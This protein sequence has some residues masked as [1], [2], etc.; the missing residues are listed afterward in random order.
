MMLLHQPVTCQDLP[1]ADQFEEIGSNKWRLSASVGYGWRVANYDGAKD[2]LMAYGF[3]SSA[4][5][6]YIKDIKSGYKIAGQV[7]YMIW[8]N[9]GL[10]ID[11]SFFHASAGIAGYVQDLQFYNSHYVYLKV[12]DNVFTNYVGASVMSESRFGNDKFRL[13]SQ[14]SLGYTMYREELLFNQQQT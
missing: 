6:D 13:G 4:V 8:G 2:N 12:E 5:D 7:H 14:Y 1:I 10:G 3:S 11:Y 9:F